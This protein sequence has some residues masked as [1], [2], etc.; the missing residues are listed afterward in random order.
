MS[1]AAKVCLVCPKACF[2]FAEMFYA[3]GWGGSFWHGTLGYARQGYRA[4]F[5]AIRIA[6]GGVWVID[7]L[8]KE[9]F[10]SYK[11]GFPFPGSNIIND[12]VQ[13]TLRSL[14]W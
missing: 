3:A 2:T 6:A 8:L 1:C 5:A 11:Q 13:R 14:H 9:G 4:S 7:V 12:S 10:N